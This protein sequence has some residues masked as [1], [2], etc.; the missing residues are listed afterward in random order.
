MESVRILEISS[1]VCSRGKVDHR[2]DNSRCEDFVMISV[3]L[4]SLHTGSWSRSESYI[5]WLGRAHIHRQLCASWD[6]Q[7]ASLPPWHHDSDRIKIKALSSPSSHPFLPPILYS[8]EPFSAEDSSLSC[9]L[10]DISKIWYKHGD[11]K[12]INCYKMVKVLE[13]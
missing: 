11:A 7:R 13:H 10:S 4:H 1:T 9:P 12:N 2:T 6:I 8:T 3:R 5:M